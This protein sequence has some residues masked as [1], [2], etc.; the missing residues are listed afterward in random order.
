MKNKI[1]AVGLSLLVLGVI[2]A[3]LVGWQ[4][5]LPPKPNQV[6]EFPPMEI[7][8]IA[9]AMDI[10]CDVSV[11]AQQAIGDWMEE[12]HDAWNAWCKFERSQQP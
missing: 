7:R 2:N 6:I 8:Q 1:K 4:R 5:E 12:N 9:H 3:I 10:G 11:E